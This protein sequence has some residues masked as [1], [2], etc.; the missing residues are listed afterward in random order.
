MHRLVAA[1]AANGLLR[2]EDGFFHRG[3]PY[4][5][6]ALRL[7]D[8]GGY[9]NGKPIGE[10]LGNGHEC[11]DLFKVKAGTEIDDSRK[12]QITMDNF[13]IAKNSVHQSLAGAI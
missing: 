6:V 8:H 4:L 13:S 11:G 7:T 5:A 2:E 10:N 3:R 1:A 9:K 12:T